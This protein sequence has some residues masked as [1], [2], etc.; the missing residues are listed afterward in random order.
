MS[1]VRQRLMGTAVTFAAMTDSW[2]AVTAN[3]RSR[4]VTDYPVTVITV[5]R[6]TR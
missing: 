3:L 6:V 2:E 1:T 4:G 5:T